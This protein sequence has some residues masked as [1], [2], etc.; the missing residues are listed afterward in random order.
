MRTQVLSFDLLRRESV[1]PF[2]DTAANRDRL[3]SA[4]RALWKALDQELTPRQKQCVEL[5][6]LRGL[7]Q[8]EVRQLLGVNKSTVCRHLKKAKRSLKRAADYA[9]LVPG[10]PRR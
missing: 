8:V 10:R 5:C 3:Q 6:V 7:S 9:A 2:G 4:A 1:T